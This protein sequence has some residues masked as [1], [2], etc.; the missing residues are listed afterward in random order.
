MALKFS[1]WVKVG[2]QELIPACKENVN[3]NFESE[4]LENLDIVD[5]NQK[6]C[7]EYIDKGYECYCL[8]STA[9]NSLQNR[10]FNLFNFRFSFRTCNGLEE[11]NKIFR[12]KK[13]KNS[14]PRFYYGLRYLSDV[15]DFSLLSLKKSGELRVYYYDFEEKFSTDIEVRIPCYDSKYYDPKY[16]KLCC[17]SIWI[18]TYT[19]GMVSSIDVI[20][21]KDEKEWYHVRNNGSYHYVDLHNVLS[22]VMLLVNDCTERFRFYYWEALCLDHDELIPFK[23][24]RKNLI[25]FYKPKKLENEDLDVLGTF[26]TTIIL[27]HKTFSSFLYFLIYDKRMQFKAL[28][29]IDISCFYAMGIS[30]KAEVLLQGLILEILKLLVPI[31]SRQTVVIDLDKVQVTQI[32]VHNRLNDREFISNVFSLPKYINWSK[33]EKMSNLFYDAPSITFDDIYKPK[34]T[35]FKHLLFNEQS[36][37]DLALNNVVCSVTMEKILASKL[38]QSLFREIIAT[39]INQI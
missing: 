23:L 14:N 30:F 36:L 19:L 18:L 24:N 26:K 34:A 8:E 28:K 27:I 17:R 4:E 7:L 22:G 6:P 20:R 12:M 16:I 2:G 3:L 1:F 32:L 35:L 37:K 5:S 38:P 25:D 9:D 29:K 15:S 11:E 21:I 31:S 13:N 39:K 33:D 10:I